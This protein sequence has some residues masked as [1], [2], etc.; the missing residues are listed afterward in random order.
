MMNT[1]RSL[2]IAA[3]V[4]VLV[5]GAGCK[6][7]NEQA[8][9]PADQQPLV[10]KP[11]ASQQ[12]SADRVVVAGRVV[13]SLDAASYTYANIETAEGNQWV[14]IPQ[15]ELEAGQEVVFAP[16]ME[17]QNLESK[18]LGKTFD[19]VVFSSGVSPH[20]VNGP[21]NP[22]MGAPAGGDSF[23]E[24]LQ[25]E[26][27]RPAMGDQMAS[28]G[29]GAAVVASADVQVEKAEGEN[30]YTVGELHAQSSELNDKQVAVRGRVMKVSR[31]IMG[32][33]WIH[34]QDGSGN[35]ADNTH[36]LV[37]TT[38]A[39]PEKDSVV[40]VEGILQANK[41]FGSGYRYDVI[42]EDAEI[43]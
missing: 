20:G 24:A 42:I 4:V 28:G 21:A 22:A 12:E 19:S 3:A 9:A 6:S 15:T 33:N 10:I 16:G 11:E 5:G 25:S 37:V 14:A 34:I 31:M 30:A 26:S 8:G 38:M 39:E 36:D 17:M 1:F 27:G 23:A 35:P 41:D 13:E 29:S 40:V 32:K 18:S 43:K 2:I 7:N